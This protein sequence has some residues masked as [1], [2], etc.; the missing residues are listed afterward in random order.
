MPMDGLFLAAVRK[1][2]NEHL[3]GGHVQKIFQPTSRSIMLHIR[4][5]G[6]SHLLLASCEAGVARLQRTQLDQPHPP[7]PPAFCMLLRKHLEGSRFCGA[8][9]RGLE[10]VVS[11]RFERG[12]KGQAEV[13][14]LMVELT[15]RNANLVLVDE[16][17]TVLDAITRVPPDA[18][19]RVLIPGA[20]Y[21]L[22]PAED[23]RDPRLLSP[24]ALPGLLAPGEPLA[25]GLFRLLEGF[26]PISA[27]RLVAAGGLD[28]SLPAGK[29][30]PDGWQKLLERFEAWQEALIEE[31]FAPCLDPEASR[32]QEQFWP[33]P[34]GPGPYEPFPTTGELLDRVFGAREEAGRLEKIRSP[35]AR[36]VQTALKR[37]QRK[38]EKQ[39][40]ELAE[41]QGDLELRVLG[42]LLLANLYRIPA[43]AREV[44]LEDYTQDP[45]VP[46][47][48]P[49]DPRLS[50]SENAQAFFDRY[51]RAKRRLERTSEELEHSREEAK[52]LE[53]LAF[54]IEAADSE[55]ALR[56]LAEEMERQGYRPPA[57]VF[58]EPRGK[59][60]D[61]SRAGRGTRAGG[62]RG[63]PLRYRSS[64]GLE[65]LVGRNHQENDR[66]TM[67]LARPDE[68]WFHVRQLPGAH[69]LLRTTSDEPPLKSLEEA[70]LLAAYHSKARHS[71][72]VPVDVARRRQ[73]RK[74]KGA[75]P[76][77]VLYEPAFTLEVTPREELLPPRID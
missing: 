28:P 5:P 16:D 68:W 10:R 50:P 47:R 31:R 12:P 60:R 46:R 65:I 41:A 14:E 15:G 20:E 19:S 13:R 25:E 21:E 75:R 43:G 40:A 73:V 6:Q 54:H 17:G 11:L 3:L 42:E 36:T 22:P 38:I 71:S 29:L 23:K 37:V 4:T 1:E 72:H 35:L 53:S 70:A 45:P 52:Y 56:A 62:E 59:V 18:G 39:E 24:D 64:D 44:E 76:G 7:V 2:L 27:E 63:Q 48:I 9:Q 30:G 32:P 8:S 51:A 74:Y 77:Q 66:I 69:V 26:S 33:F 61:G 55:E 49:L 58:G 57:D 67:E 34:P